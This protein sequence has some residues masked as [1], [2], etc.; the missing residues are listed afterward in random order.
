MTEF[1]GVKQPDFDTMAGKHA[2]AAGQ[3]EE[4][5][6]ALHRELQ[7]AGLDTSPAARL[8]ELAGR[9]ATQAEDLR[10]RQHLVHELQRQKVTFGRSM[11]AGSFLEMPDRLEAAR[12][13]LDGTLAGRAALAAANG[14]D[15]A[16]T[17]LEK[18]ASRTG[19]AEFVKAFMGALGARGV[20]RMPGSLATQLRDVANRGDSDR[21]TSLSAQG[22]KALRML[23]MTLAKATDPK[24]P[25]YL[26]SGFLKDLATEGRSQH[27]AGSLTYSG[28]QA[29]ALIW[30]AHDGKTPY[31]K[32]FMEV[33]GRDVIVHEYEQ[34]KD[35]WAASKDLLGRT[36]ANAQVPIIDL[37]GATGIGTLL[38]PGT[39]AGV[40][41]AKGGSSVVD[42]LFHAAKS[43]REASHALLNHTP[44]GWKTSM[45][46]YLLTTRWGASLYLKD[47]APFND[48]LVTATTGQDATSQRLAAELTKT[49]ADEVRG[50]FG[51]ADSGNLEIRNREAFD[52][53][54]ALS[55]PL[56]RAIAA[57]VDQLSRLYLNHATF[58]KV[59][60]EDM[61]Y[62]LVLATSNDAGFEALVR[63]QTE[64]M[65]A[66]LDTVP[67]VGLNASNAGRLGFTLADVKRFDRNGNGVV[68][69]ADTTQF[70][71]DRTVEE[72]TPFNH[73][74]EVRRQVLIAQGL[75][76]KKA[77][78]SL[79]AMVANAIGL[80]PAPGA[81]RIG[82]LAVGAFGE[83]AGRGYEKLSGAAYDELS[84]QVAKRISEQGRSLDETYRTLA[85]NQTA[86]ERLAE[87]M[88][89]TA[90]LNK[91]MLDELR[92]KNQ[93]FT[94]GTPPTLKPF[95]EMTPQEYSS[96]LEWTRTIGGS[97][98]LLNGFGATFYNTQKISSHLG[99]RIQTPGGDE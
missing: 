94:N 68:D 36:F 3:L 6:Q 47:H 76:D 83:L 95:A 62:A 42:D 44:A 97:S 43:S 93:T 65:R 81:K 13:L 10:R 79:K 98:D 70:L 39:Q 18:Y 25:A 30:R 99:L 16:L 22:Q 51:K 7:G 52:R 77:D 38:R 60:P 61:S 21:V 55:Y 53:Y 71:K 58:D 80:L 23:S 27:K 19:D 96:F 28:Y 1:S 29:Q 54:A 90:M 50:A 92:L 88:L 46:D 4:L 26:G 12:G 34:R 56:G 89:A 86:V 66:A 67:P 63:A 9:I 85:D 82:E 57:N 74:V 17:E 84:R 5:A 49:V 15:R 78:E 91:G 64:H 40:P 8:R 87:Q 59:T 32:E 48:L 11:P 41:G 35:E 31:S 45:L 2:Q 33:V 73:I 69:A 24:N 75:N 37:A 20:T 14:D 72:A